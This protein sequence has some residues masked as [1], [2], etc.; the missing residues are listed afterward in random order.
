MQSNL[1]P[2]SASV[3]ALTVVLGA[4]STKKPLLRSSANAGEKRQ[5]LCAPA[6]RLAQARRSLATTLMRVASRTLSVLGQLVDWQLLVCEQKPLLLQSQSSAVAVRACVVE[7]LVHE[8]LCSAWE[9]STQTHAHS[10]QLPHARAW[11]LLLL[12]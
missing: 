2:L 4:P 8:T 3:S 9:R 10:K 7:A 6:E 5:Q 12:K 11:A 1:R